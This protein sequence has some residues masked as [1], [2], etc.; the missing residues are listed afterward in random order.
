MKYDPEVWGP[1]YWFFLHSITHCY[2]IN[3]SDITKRKFYD[4]VINLPL[5][6]PNEEIGNH[7]SI[8][9]DKYPVTPYLVGRESFKRWMVFIHNKINN[10]L[11][12]DEIPYWKAM[13]IYE[14]HYIPRTIRISE[15]LRIQ[16]HHIT[17]VF[18]FILLILIYIFY[19][20]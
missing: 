8:L 7:F 6:I 5:F 13:K 18:I 12:K 19:K 16:K 17:A 1:H 15:S 14:H 20:E 11:N 9:L 10:Q 2:P 4:L 3:P